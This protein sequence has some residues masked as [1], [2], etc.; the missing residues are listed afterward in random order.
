SEK[1]TN[2]KNKDDIRLLSKDDSSNK[3]T[4]SKEPSLQ[5]EKVIKS[6]TSNPQNLDKNVANNSESNSSPYNIKKDNAVTQSINELETTITKEEL[7]KASKLR[8]KNDTAVE[9]FRYTLSL[10][11]TFTTSILIAS[12]ISSLICLSK[13]SE[14]TKS[15]ASVV[16]NSITAIQTNGLHSI[17]YQGEEM[18]VANATFYD[19][20]GDSEVGTSN[21]PNQISDGLD[22][23]KNTFSKFNKKLL[24]LKKYGNPS[25]CPAKYPIYAG[26]GAADADMAG[27]CYPFTEEVCKSSNFWAAA[28]WGQIGGS[29]I[30][31][32]VDKKLTYDSQGNSYI[33]QSNSENGKSTKLPYFD[34]TFLTSN[35]FDNS[36]LSLATVRENVAFPFR[37]VDKNGI[38]YYEFY[39]SQDTVR[40]NNNN[41]LDYLGYNNTSE[42][43]KDAKGN[44]G[45]FPYNKASEGQTN[46]LNF[47]HGVRMDIP[48]NMTSDGKINGKDMIFE[49]SGDDDVWVY[50]DGEL[51]LDIGGNHGEVKGSIN[52]AQNTAT[53]NKV[54]NS[55][56]A[57][58]KRT[59]NKYNTGANTFTDLGIT[60]VDGLIT[61]K[62]DNFT[63]TLK[64]NLK[65]TTKT[66]TLSFFYM[67]RCKNVANLKLSFNLPEPTL[68]NVV[69]EINTN[70]ANKAFEKELSEVTKNDTFKYDVLD[71][72]VTRKAEMSLNDKEVVSFINEFEKDHSLLVQQ[73]SLAISTRNLT[74]LYNTKWILKDISGEISKGETLLVTDTR[75]N[76]TN[77]FKFANKSNDDV[78]VLTATYNN[79]PKLGTFELHCNVTDKYKNKHNDFE[80][81]SFTFTITHSKVFQGASKST[82]YNGDYTLTTFNNREE[83]LTTNN[84]K[85]S[86]HP[87]EKIKIT[88][89]PVKTHITATASLKAEDSIKQ[90]MATGNFTSNVKNKTSTGVISSTNN[91]LKFTYSTKD[92]EAKNAKEA[93][94]TIAPKKKETSKNPA[95]DLE[96]V[97]D[98]DAFDG[99]PSTADS[100]KLNLWIILGCISLIFCI[101]TFIYLFK[102]E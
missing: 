65:D 2:E 46:K 86:L 10:K 48:F 11:R 37:R 23:S 53:V 31:G 3:D 34:K 50:I 74:D 7:K 69:N 28:N 92:D 93:I 41:Q 70:N 67:E 43:V 25:E 79:T 29:A 84:G 55:Q 102:I 4:S 100:T 8:N 90:I 63:S 58:A 18:Y 45:F 97:N 75:S 5:T 89:I 94:A 98:G 73:K 16:K 49:F 71:K 13:I 36:Q 81:D 82:N 51:V 44:Y 66:H 6:D 42:Q 88:N 9:K 80:K 20:H 64:N 40:F 12:F 91:I 62:V 83:N 60:N 14:A 17:T 76:V 99:T 30:Q 95:S 101:S 15:S 72:T 1:N 38:I 52:F 56:V 54:R 33:T 19:Y 32:L 26:A 21:T 61:D 27:I 35:K 47:V 68:L 77:S 22:I 57:F 87:G 78:P 59:M 96:S 85:I 39:S 24:E